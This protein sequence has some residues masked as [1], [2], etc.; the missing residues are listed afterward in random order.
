VADPLI[1]ASGSKIRLKIL[2]DAGVPVVAETAAV[3]EESVKTAMK[4]EGASATDTAIALAEL[5]ARRVSLRR[6]GALVLGADQMLECGGVWFDKPVDEA[7]LRAQ[8]T[9]LRGKKHRLIS[10]CVAMRDGERLW[11]AAPHAD[12]T[13]RPFSEAFLDWYVGAGGEA[14]LNS[15]GGYQIE[16]VGAQ[17]FAK[18]TGDW[19]TVMGLPLYPLLDFLRLQGVLTA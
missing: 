10:A 2:Q 17:L 13:L 11:H 18:V 6:P 4:A 14:L 3:D 15:V 12:V 5:K 8:L 7:N 19:F 1:L 9:T 16:G